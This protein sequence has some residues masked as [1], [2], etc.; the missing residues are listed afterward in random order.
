MDYFFGMSTLAERLNE[1]MNDKGLKPADLVRATGRKS[2]SV[3]AWLHGGTKNLKGENLVILAR[4]LDV[5][6]AWLA[7]GAGDRKRKPGSVDDSAWPFAL[8][9]EE[10]FRKLSETD[11]VR[12]ET[13]LIAIAHNLKIDIGKDSP[14]DIRAG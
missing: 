4:L 7:H 12:I 10:K 11:Q 5:S 3:H 9:D 2:S 13:S 14:T 1:A 8:V 6:E